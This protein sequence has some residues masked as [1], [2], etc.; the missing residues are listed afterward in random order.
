MKFAWEITNKRLNLDGAERPVLAI[1]GAV[2]GPLINASV[3]DKVEVTVHNKLF[4]ERVSFHW[5]GI[6]QIGTPQMDGVGLITEAPL[7]PGKTKVYKYVICK[8]ETPLAPR[9]LVRHHLCRNGISRFVVDKPGTYWYHSHTGSQYADGLFGPL[10]V[11]NPKEK[12]DY[13]DELIFMFAEWYHR[14]GNE[15]MSEVAIIARDHNMHIC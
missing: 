11:Q 12:Y 9:V 10:I 6:H 4:E 14:D 2:P 13:E 1:N 3:N 8:P 5:H 7:E 15:I